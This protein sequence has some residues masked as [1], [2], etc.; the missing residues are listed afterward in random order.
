[1]S[2]CLTCFVVKHGLTWADCWV[3]CSLSPRL[4][5]TALGHPGRP[6][7]P[8]APPVGSASRSASDPAATPLRGTVAG[9]ALD[10]AGKKGK[11]CSQCYVVTSVVIVLSPG[12]GGS[13]VNVD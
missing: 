6:G 2:Q 11:R 13:S 3:T 9:S 7:P 10:R 5:E 1:M 4:L 8:V 12:S